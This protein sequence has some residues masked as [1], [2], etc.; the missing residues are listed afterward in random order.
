MTGAIDI[1]FL[2]KEFEILP[3][4]FRSAWDCICEWGTLNEEDLHNLM[5]KLKKEGYEIFFE[6]DGFFLNRK[7][8]GE[9]L[10]SL[11]FEGDF[12]PLWLHF[13]E[14]TELNLPFGKELVKIG[15]AV[16]KSRE[17][18]IRR[19]DGVDGK[20]KCPHYAEACKKELE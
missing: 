1:I 10:Q 17:G 15:R 2:M 19:Y 9:L 3:C 7:V 8:L 4:M 13:S 5:R 11:D 12:D 18:F 20:F 6:K 16:Q 14:D